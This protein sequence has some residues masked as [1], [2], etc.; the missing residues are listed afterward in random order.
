MKKQLHKHTLFA[1][2]LFVAQ[3]TYAQSPTAPALGFNVFLEK[4]ATFTNNETEGPVAMGGNLTI[5]A[6][7]QVSTNYTGTYTVNGV[8][9]TLLVGGKVIY[10]GG[11]SLQVNQNGYVKIG[12][13]TGSYVWYK[14]NNNAYSPIRITPGSNYNSAP[15]ISLSANS[16]ALGVSASNNPVF[17][18]NLID[19]GSAFTAMKYRSTSMSS[20]ADNT[21]LTNANG[22]PLLLRTLLP[23]Q[24]K[25]TLAT[26]IN[27][28]NITGADMNTVQNFT[29]N[30]QPDATRI[31][32]VNVN[33]P[34]TFNW[35][36][37]NSG[38][39][40][41]SNTPYI[42]YNFYNTTTLN[43]QGNG[44]V[45]G[46]VFAPYAD[47]NKTA[48]QANI[49]GQVIAQSY[50]H[51]GGENHHFPFTTTVN[52]CAAKP[53]ASY[54]IN[55]TPQC[56]A[57]NAFTFTSTSTGGTN[58]SYS[59][60]FGD[61]A[62][63]TAQNPSKTYTA[64]GTYTVKLVVTGAGGKDSVSKTVT[65]SSSTV[66]AGFSVNDSSQFLLGNAFSFTS[67][68]NTTG[69]TYLWSFGDGTYSTDKNPFKSYLL[70]GTYQVKQIVTSSGGCKDSITK[71]VAVKSVLST[72]AL[73]N[74]NNGSQCLDGNS[75]KF[76]S[77]SL[78]NLLSL[79][80][81]FGD[82]ETSE[83]TNPVKSFT[84]PGTYAI[85][86]VVS[87]LGGKDS[88]TTNVTVNPSPAVD[89]TVN[90]N[91]QFLPVNNFIFTPTGSTTGNTYS[92]NF[93]DATSSTAVSPSKTYASTGTY[94]VKQLVTSAAGCKDSST[95]TVSVKM[96]LP[97]VAAFN[98]N[99][100]TQ[101]TGS[102]SFLFTGAAT[103]SGSLTYAWSFGDAT[104]SA[105]SS[106]VKSYSAAGTYQVKLVV[107]GLGGK[108]SV[109]KTVTI[110]T[111]PTPGFTIND[112]SQFLAINRFIFNTTSPVAG[113][114][115][116]WNFGDGTF[117]N[118][119]NPAKTYLLAG[120]YTVTQKVI[121]A[122]GC[123]STLSKTIVV[124]IPLLTTA[125]FNINNS[126]QCLN[127]NTFHFTSISVGSLLSLKWDFGDGSTSDNASPSKTY[128]VAGTYTVK[129]IVSGLGGKDSITASVTVHA[130]PVKDFAVNDTAQFLSGN[131]FSCTPSG[132]TTGNSYFWDF[133]DG[134]TSTAVSPVKSYASIGTREIKLVVT[135]ANGCKDSSYTTIVVKSPSLT[136]AS[137]IIDNNHTQCLGDNAFQFK[138]TATGS[139]TL[140]Y[141]WDFGDGTSSA[142]ANPVK[143]YS[144][145]GTYQVKVVVNGAGGKDS[146]TR[147]V[148]VAAAP[149]VGFTVND[150]SQFL[151]GNIFSFTSATASGINIYKWSF[152]DGSISFDVNPVK[153]YLLP[154]TYTVKQTVTSLAGCRDS[155]TR[156]VVVKAVGL[157][158]ALFSVNNTTQCLTGNA[159]KITNNTLGTGLLSWLWDFG[160]GTISSLLNPVKT[161]TAPGTYTIKLL[162]NALGGKDSIVQTVTVLPLPLTGFTRNDSSQF[163][164]GNS[165]TFTP[166]NN[167]AGNTYSW[168]FGDGT[169]S[170][171]PIPVKSFADT[172]IY[173]V[174]QI[175]TSAG[176]CKDSISLMVNVK[177]VIPTL[178]LFEVNEAAQCL[179][180]NAFS[181]LNRSLG[182]GLLAC[183]WDF[184]DGTTSSLLNPLKTYTVPG[185]YFVKL[186]VGALGGLDSLGITV[187][188]YANPTTGFSINDSAQFLAGNNFR[189]S[190]KN[191]ASLN[192]YKWDFGDGTFSSDTE[193]VKTFVAAGTYIIKQI[194]TS[195]FGC[196]DSFINTVIVKPVLATIASFNINNTAQC[197]A[198]NTFS[199]LSTSLGS[200][201]LKCFWEFGDGSISSLLNPVKTY[202]VASTY[203]VKLIIEGLGGRDSI[204]KTIIV[205]AAVAGFTVNDTT[206]LVLGNNFTFQ[207][208]GTI[209]G[210]K[211]FW[212][213]GDGTNDT[214]AH[215]SKSFARAG[216][217]VIKQLVTSPEGC[218][219]SFIRIINVTPLLTT[220]AD[221]VPGVTTACLGN[222]LTFFNASIGSG[223]LSYLW[224]FGDG[225]TS[226]DLC[227][228]KHYNATGS[229]IVKLIVSG[230]GGVD[231]LSKTVTVISNAI[232]GFAIND[233]VQP[234]TGNSFSFTSAAVAGYTYKWH[235][236]DQSIST[237]A[238]PLKTYLLPGHYE[239]KQIASSPN[240]CIDSLVQI[241][242]VESDSVGS[243]NGGGLESRGLGGAVT[244]RDYLRLKNNIDTKIDYSRLPLFAK[245]VVLAKK[246]AQR[247]SDMMPQHLVA[248]DV[249]RISTPEDLVNLTI[250]L[251]VLSVD[252][253]QNNQAKASVLGI[254]TADGAYNHTKQVCD[255]LR[256]A[257]LT[258]IDTVR[259]QNYSFIRFAL[260]QE[261]NTVEYC[262]S[263]VVGNNPS[264]SSY[265]LQTSWLIS[266]YQD[267]DTMYTFQVWSTQPSSSE[268]LINDILNNLKSSMPVS[269]ID[270]PR[271]PKAFVT[272]GQRQKEN[273]ILNIQNIT[274]D[275]Y[276]K[277]V[278]TQRLNEQASSERI[279]IQLALGRF[280]NK[281]FSIPVK[282]GY[283]YEGTIYLENISEDGI[284][285]ADGNWGLDYDGSNTNLTQYTIGNEPNRVY[286]NNEFAVYRN[287]TLKCNTDDYMTIYKAISQGNAKTNLT[288]YN[289]LKFFAKG[290]GK[291]N[292]KLTK[293]AI[294]SWHDQYNMDI[295]LDS[296]GKTYNIP[297]SDLR[298]PIMNIP[299][300]AND[301]RL[302]GFT[303]T[304][305]GS[306]RE[307]FNFF[308]NDIAFSTISTGIKEETK[309]NPLGVYPN[310]SAGSFSVSFYS[311]R[312]ETME[313]V[314]TDIV[315]KM[316]FSKKVVAL[317]GENITRVDM[318]APATGIFL[319][320][321]KGKGKQYSTV[322]I[323]VD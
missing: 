259:I 145:A 247:L 33:A 177:A 25:V 61:G 137:F 34:G 130:L 228:S 273:L 252:Y 221:F 161:Y 134:T 154:G 308:V 242:I 116:Q 314:V 70:V 52:G 152:G 160:D 15:K 22:I 222:A 63:S 216:T 299:F 132:S 49:E 88:I 46:T 54:N 117:S 185:T 276:G 108:D 149:A 44:A 174:K 270:Q 180:G 279:E 107:I 135:S 47:I 23:S 271:L 206:Q 165:F 13:S 304:P 272:H 21:L 181:F 85:K 317:P 214:L 196:R 82:G 101:C 72:V 256:G 146:I 235:F 313:L 179:T 17:Q 244:A 37:W 298:S 120:N 234:L 231:S 166:A 59:W 20:C 311:D 296:V 209:S 266:E 253:T 38:G 148:V 1:L 89:F 45:E 140:T 223:I 136:I 211:Y 90:S 158:S 8:K 224:D 84:S 286:A 39:I 277:I 92:W 183:L 194:V 191:N 257:T 19:F 170:N 94:T 203:H 302:L 27:Y 14:D 83:N 167:T 28:L 156:S 217:Y 36:V 176:G 32:I 2:L 57:G 67:S 41:G 186:R 303:F 265:S 102:N 238:S 172:G 51:N 283:E 321:I 285:M 62:T 310:P 301:V 240:G 77:I 215:P 306:G 155:F 292:V 184:G 64:A 78:G 260:K 3:W 100:N 220:L 201:I 255:R 119:S 114:S 232:T 87:G 26:G 24:V 106:P 11:N 205:H 48:N 6:S 212:D 246:A 290:T 76:T 307:D 9:V 322:K 65:V 86:L 110:G 91:E 127:A 5:G 318:N 133:G 60:S 103:G 227:P 29:F 189:F 262:I 251:E 53:V 144:A 274:D 213:F 58:L 294:V 297:F 50:I 35:N 163:I 164:I 169:F 30:N 69:N 202:T 258:S 204:T 207:S 31:L 293:N 131:S 18:K 182:S 245:P 218:K 73:F 121:S 79:K 219:D 68:G 208:G 74:I 243:G 147:N 141:G 233:S 263:F 280:E 315:G 80:W 261:D 264:R 249:P 267:E 99:K 168:H 229:Y 281:Q 254:K 143:S 190:L 126:I 42:L 10:S 7:Y 128:A 188:V 95:I 138:A 198:G 268:K 295:T 289:N 284:Y 197:L 320:N 118:D 193:A 16:Q 269:Q 75:F 93:G 113:N 288:Q 316:I 129:L 122:T 55:N 195:P 40:G 71:T 171:D 199:F 112:S 66:A 12:D 173:L 210:N 56:L 250:A 230:I 225:T 153:I 105:L 96:P 287:V 157:T 4:N 187:T 291:V 241:V 282:D 312:E 150:S 305:A 236:G 109:V 125:L 162:A 151:V 139:G 319:V 248:N 323:L 43:I 200:G 239:V 97:T 175:I 142:L 237:D 192:L 98:I 124:K 278:F 309:L 159:F 104:S 226:T 123:E 115:Y 275:T 178:A 111:P 81:Y 300:T